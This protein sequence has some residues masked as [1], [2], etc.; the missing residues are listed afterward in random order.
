MKVLYLTNVPSPYKVE[1]FNELSKLCKLTVIYERKQAADRN[2]IWVSSSIEAYEKIYLQGKKFRHDAA[3]SIEILKYLR[4][5]SYDII[6]IGGYSTPTAMLAILYLNLKNIPFVLSADGGVIK[7]DSHSIYKIK[8]FFIGK[9]FAWLSTGAETNK[10]LEYYGANPDYIFQY[11]FT[12][13]LNKDILKTTISIEEKREIKEKLNILTDK[14][15]ISVGQFIYRKGFDILL[16]AWENIN[17]NASLYIIGGSPTDEYINLVRE[18]KLKNVNFVDFKSKADL[19]DYYKAADIFVLPTREDIWGLVINEAMACGLP[20]I[21][22]DSC[23]AGLEMVRDSREGYIISTEDSASLSKKIRL[24]LDSEGLR[25]EISNNCL[26]RIKEY[27][28]E[29]MAARHLEI[30]KEIVVLR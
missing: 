19:K 21:T 15:V 22:T 8:R 26:K 13:L 11:P 6:V 30:F 4:Q 1:F 17:D 29:N 20:I 16:K 24:L 3:F 14:V 23:V 18:L 10:Y 2:P 5:H 9:A 27:T 7:K 25:E 12:S 28:I